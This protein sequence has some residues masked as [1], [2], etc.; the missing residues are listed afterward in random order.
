MAQLSINIASP[1]GGVSTVLSQALSSVW[2]FIIAYGESKS[3]SAQIDALNA[4]SDEDLAR[5]G[6]TR[7]GI[8]SYVFS[9]V[10]FL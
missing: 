5:R 2:E 1:A 8:V 9:D 3:R 7:S 4:M 10:G 6:I